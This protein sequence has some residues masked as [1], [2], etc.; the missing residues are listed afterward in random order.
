MPTSG[1][2]Q[3]TQVHKNWPPGATRS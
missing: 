1:R 2:R 3:R